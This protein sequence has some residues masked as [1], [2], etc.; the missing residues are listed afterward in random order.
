[1][2]NA[3]HD[4][5]LVTEVTTATPQKLQLM[6]VEAALRFA[7]QAREHWAASREAEAA[8]A[9]SRSQQIVTQ[10]ISALNP[11]PHP[12]LVR[13]VAA[14]YLF[15]FRAL[16]AAQLEH[17]EI[18]LAEAVSVLEIER[19]TWRQVCVDHGSNRVAPLWNE[20]ES[21]AGGFSLTA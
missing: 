3:A 20:A 1:M 12:E 5:Y 14:I 8:E 9:L 10:V 4:S 15:V 2:H 17:D 18:K 21:A 16:L 13:Q 11:E 7:H 19:D 6:L